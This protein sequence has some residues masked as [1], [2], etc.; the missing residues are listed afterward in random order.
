MKKFPTNVYNFP[1]ANSNAIYS[2]LNK[3]YNNGTPIQTAK[4]GMGSNIGTYTL[5]GNNCTIMTTNALQIGG[6]PIPT[7]V[8]PSGFIQYENAPMEWNLP[9]H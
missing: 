7:I 3:L 1:D 5:W 4:E 9:V 2:Y 8:S 6:V